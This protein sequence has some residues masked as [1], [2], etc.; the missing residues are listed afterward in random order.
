MLDSGF[1]VVETRIFKTLKNRLLF[2]EPTGG[3]GR[4]RDPFGV[5]PSVR[6]SVRNAL[7]TGITLLHHVQ[8]RPNLGGIGFLGNLNFWSC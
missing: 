8:F 3:E 2:V 1:K 7:K 4:L 6:A 5:R